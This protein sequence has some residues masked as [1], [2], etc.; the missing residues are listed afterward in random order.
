[1]EGLNMGADDY[2]VKPFS[3]D[4]LLARI[5]ALLRRPHETIGELLTLGDLSLD[6]VTKRAT[7]ANQAIALSPKEYAL[8]EYFM[9]NPGRILSR[10]N[11]ISHVWDGDT[12]ILPTSI[13]SFITFLRHKI[14]K[15]F[16]SPSLLHTIRGFGYKL[17]VKP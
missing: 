14:D 13:E 15:P 16:N 4:E 8:L 1:V 7:R 2:L 10:Q 9:R 12:D 5:R 17:D 11:L 3:F 6:C